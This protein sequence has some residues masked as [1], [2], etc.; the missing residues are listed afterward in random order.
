VR[1]AALRITLNYNA[2]QLPS[3]AVVPRVYQ[4]VAKVI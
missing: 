3:V 1:T 2:V 4:Q